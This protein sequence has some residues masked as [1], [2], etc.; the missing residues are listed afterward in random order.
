L[1][2]EFI[3]LNENISGL[4]VYH[5]FGNLNGILKI[6]FMAFG[7]LEKKLKKEATNRQKS[8]WLDV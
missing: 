4:Q 8:S 7:F 6:I 1:K 3:Y 5:L 2:K